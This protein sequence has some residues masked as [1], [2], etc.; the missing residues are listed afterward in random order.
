MHVSQ[1]IQRAGAS[2]A[3]FVLLDGQ[4][5]TGQ[6]T[7]QSPSQQTGT[8]STPAAPAIDTTG[9]PTR[10]TV[11]RL[12]LKSSGFDKNEI[13]IP[14]GRVLFGLDNQSGVSNFVLQLSQHTASGAVAVPL[15]TAQ[16]GR[17]A[18]AGSLQAPVH[19]PRAKLDWRGIQN[20]P[21]GT[22]T[23]TEATHTSW[24]CKITVTA[25]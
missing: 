25:E 7:Q 22:Y 17:V 20:L 15:D 3:V 13:T 4:S 10:T 11:I 12:V 2:L 8:S 9:V 16:S 23:L 5:A 21:A 1:L 6:Q 18:P 24:V 19:S 14:A